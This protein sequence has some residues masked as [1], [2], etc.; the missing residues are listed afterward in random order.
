MVHG[1]RV[2]KL[3][4]C[5]AFALCAHVQTEKTAGFAGWIC[6]VVLQHL[7]CLPPHDFWM[8]LC[9]EC[10]IY[11]NNSLQQPIV[12]S[13]S[14][15]HNRTASRGHIN[16]RANQSA[17]DPSAHRRPWVNMGNCSCVCNET[18]AHSVV[19]QSP[20][21]SQCAEALFSMRCSDTVWESVSG[22]KPVFLNNLPPEACQ[23]A[24][25]SSGHSPPWQTKTWRRIRAKL[26]GGNNNALGK[27][28]A[29]TILERYRASYPSND[30]HICARVM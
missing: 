20:S 29:S 13:R 21:A 7:P 16:G 8:R 17:P 15:A 1:S 23:R 19:E 10:L 26:G 14:T 25:T 12:Q 30:L 27:E 22:C 18:S 9:S 3:P 28:Y 11:R 5:G 4:T 6:H 24:R 2:R